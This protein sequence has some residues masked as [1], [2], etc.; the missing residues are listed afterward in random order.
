MGRPTVSTLL[1]LLLL[2]LMS[3]V[4]RGQISHVILGPFTEQQRAGVMVG[5]VASASNITKDVTTNEFQ[6]LRYE[7]L[8]PSN[9]QTASLF[10]LNGQTGGVFTSAMI[11][12]EAVCQFQEECLLKFDVTVSSEVTAFLRIISV[13]VNV[14]DVND[15]VP[16]FPRESITLNIPEGNNPGATY[17]LPNAVDRDTRANSVVGYNLLSTTSAFDLDVERNLDDTF[18]V[19][20]FVNAVLDRE[21]R[22]RYLVRLTARDG[23]LQPLTGTLNIN[24]NVTDVNDNAPKFTK[25]S[26]SYSVVENAPTGTVIGRVVATDLDAGMNARI[27]YSFSSSSSRSKLQDLFAIHPDTGEIKIIAPL[28]Y[29]S[30]NTFNAI[31][32][33]RDNGVPRQEGQAQLQMV[34]LDT[35]NN[36]PRVEFLPKNPLYDRT[37][38]IA[39]DAKIP[40]LVGTMKVEDNDPGVSGTVNCHSSHM[41]FRINKLDEGGGF[42]VLLQSQLDREVEDRVNVTISCA[43]AGAPP[44]TAQTA[45]SV[46]VGDVND[47]APVFTQHV[48]MANLTE[49]VEENVE[50][51]RV[52][53]H[54]YDKGINSQFYYYLPRENEMF[55]L[56]SNT[57]VMTSN[58]LF[59]REVN[60]AVTVIIKAIDEGDPAMTGTATVVVH[61]LDENDNA[62]TLETTEFHVMEGSGPETYIGRLSAHDKDAGINAEVE[63]YM[64]AVTPL[65][66]FT[67]YQDGQIR[68]A[69]E[70][71]IDREMKEFYV[72]EIYMNDKGTPRMSSSATVTVHVLDVNDNSPEVLYPNAKNNTVTIMWD[73]IPKAPFARINAVDADDGDNAKLSFFI[74]GGNKNNLFQVSPDSGAVFLRRYIE[75]TD[76]TFHRLKIAVLDNGKPHQLETQALFNIRIDLT[77]ATFARQE[78]PAEMERNILIAGIVGGATIVICIV[79]LVVIFQ[80]RTTAR[81]P[82]RTKDPSEWQRDKMSIQEECGKTEMEKA[83]WKVAHTQYKPAPSD[84]DDLDEEEQELCDDSDHMTM[85]KVVSLPWSNDAKAPGRRTG[86]DPGPDQYKKQEFYTFCKVSVWP[87]V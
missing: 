60:S 81:H 62:P 79:I 1:L 61:I 12:R 53:A 50:V 24:I 85:G 74:A 30:G 36:P 11:D 76:I 18:R 37:V 29:V 75:D 43:D 28:Q 42:L 59:D 47:N 70:V 65:P 71:M 39:E 41:S 13:A 69:S 34:I 2:N 57:G 3:R 27:T 32:K 63:Y 10:T 31:I 56:D 21:E 40:T 80:V 84:P 87:A 6:T 52:S 78:G 9:L 14:T 8:D 20:L 54:D 15:N 82:R 49:N 64:K 72:L 17:P 35:G 16:T 7:F 19:S 77:N 58:M 86:G 55:T 66:P 33:A 23:G 73:Q 83:V 25:Q 46:I 67:V 68:T 38:L 44:M 48:Y 51:I 5:N 22:D 45:F 26:Y 4:A